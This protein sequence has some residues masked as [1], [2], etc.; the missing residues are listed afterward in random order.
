MNKDRKR[1]FIVGNNILEKNT[2]AF[3]RL[4]FLDWII[5]KRFSIMT[6]KNLTEQDSTCIYSD[7]ET[8]THAGHCPINLMNVW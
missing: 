5:I 6:I 3:I 8:A 7:V 1:A 2:S 4:S